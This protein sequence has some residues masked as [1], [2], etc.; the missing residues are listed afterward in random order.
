MIYIKM[1]VLLFVWSV[2][3]VV[4]KSE[5]YYTIFNKS[6]INRLQLKLGGCL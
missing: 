3:E 6:Y 2:Y 1:N 5:K 4:T